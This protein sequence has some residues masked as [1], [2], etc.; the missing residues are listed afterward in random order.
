MRLRTRPR[1]VPRLRT[2]FGSQGQEHARLINGVTFSCRG[3]HRIMGESPEL[4]EEDESQEKP[5]HVKNGSKA[6]C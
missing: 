2:A 4:W 1:P 6:G 3:P 5:K